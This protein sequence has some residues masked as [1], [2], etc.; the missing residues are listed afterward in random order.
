M[1]W[2]I[3]DTHFGHIA[4]LKMQQRP[5]KDVEEMNNTIINNINA[6]VRNEN[7]DKLY[8]LGD[9]SHHIKPE[10]TIKLLNRIKCRQKYLVIGN[11]DKA[12]AIKELA[13]NLFKDIQLAYQDI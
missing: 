11:H 9:L 4:I 5:F 3:A 6:V 2:Y 8:F 12:D 13:P 7:N 10:E 1:N